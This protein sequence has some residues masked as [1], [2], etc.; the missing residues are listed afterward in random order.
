MAGHAVAAHICT[1]PLQEDSRS[2]LFLTVIAQRCAAERPIEAPQVSKVRPSMHMDA[3]HR[4]SDASIKPSAVQLQLAE[5]IAD[6]VAARLSQHTL[7]S[8]AARPQQLS[9]SAQT[10][11]DAASAAHA[12][13][14]PALVAQ[15]AGQPSPPRHPKAAAEPSMQ[16]LEWTGSG[17]QACE[18]EFL[19]ALL[20]GSPD[21]PS[22]AGQHSHP[23]AYEQDF[24]AALLLGSPGASGRMSHAAS[25]GL[26]H[27]DSCTIPERR[28]ESQAADARAQPWTAQWA[29]KLTL[30]QMETAVQEVRLLNIH[31]CLTGL[32]FLR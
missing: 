3:L 23:Q 18:D 5:R 11:L 15:G 7:H 29:G 12:A 6:A 20:Q 22:H 19:A 25:P 21:R 10:T 8:A 28:A 1:A 2:A 24:L 13:P 31:T 32:P 9:S 30:Q 4:E 26:M 14:Q 17:V 27:R 16:S